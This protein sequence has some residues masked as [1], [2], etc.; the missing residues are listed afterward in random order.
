[1]KMGKTFKKL[2][3]YLLV[4]CIFLCSYCIRVSADEL[5]YIF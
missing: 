5:S 1:M 4:S 2:A 3:I